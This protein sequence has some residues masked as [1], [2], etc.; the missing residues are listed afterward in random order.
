M[1]YKSYISSNIMH[2]GPE[3]NLRAS[4]V[5]AVQAMMASRLKNVLPP[6]TNKKGALELV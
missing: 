4:P 1:V 3:D 5:S 6:M 2:K